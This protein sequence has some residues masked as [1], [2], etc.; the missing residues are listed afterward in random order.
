MKLLLVTL[1]AC[2]CCLAA[3][4]DFNGRWDLRVPKEPRARAW[5]LEVQG[6]GTPA[7]KG[8]FVGFPGGNTD[9]IPQISVTNGVLHFSADRGQGQKKTHLEYTVRLNGGKLEGEMHNGNT[10]LEFTG[11]RAPEI[12]EHDDG[13]WKE[14]TPIA[15]FNGKDLSGWHGMVPNLALGWIVENG[16]LSNQLGANNLVSERKFWNFKIHVECK[17]SHDTN[18]GIGL[19]GRYEVQILDDYGQPP[20]THGNGALYSRILPTMNASKPIGEWQSYDV[21]LVGRD[22]TVVL[23][24]HKVIDR[25]HIDGLTAIAQSPDEGEPGPIILQGD[26]RHVEIRKVILTPLTR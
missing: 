1:L 5:W 9:P 14:G 22:V 6:A 23:N 16:A 24:D 13:T 10:T 3:D 18:S 21:R 4:S 26:H 20:D 11:V 15:L 12:D 17:L 8:S 7:I 25:K 2:S 19:R